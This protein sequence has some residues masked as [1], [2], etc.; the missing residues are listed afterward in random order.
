MRL[1]SLLGQRFGRLLVLE[2][3]D[4]LDAEVVWRCQCDC[5]VEKNV[6]ARSLRGP[7]GARTRS[8]GCLA[9]NRIEES[10]RMSASLFPGAEPVE[11]GPPP[12]CSCGWKA[13]YDYPGVGAFCDRHLPQDGRQ[14]LDPSWLYRNVILPLDRAISAAQAAA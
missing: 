3:A 7:A 8:C 6:L 5:G 11:D 2:R 1:E 13:K 12:L 4:N 10:Q 9:R 14:R